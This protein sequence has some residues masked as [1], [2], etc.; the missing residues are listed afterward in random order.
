MKYLLSLL[1]AAGIFVSAHAAEPSSGNPAEADTKTLVWPD[2]TRY[3]GSVVDDK[4]SGKGTIIWQ[5]G[6]RFVGTFKDDLRNGPGTMI[7]PDGTVYNGYF[8]NDVLVDNQRAT[9]EASRSGNRPAEMAEPTAELSEQDLAAPSAGAVT[10]LNSSVQEDLEIT[11]NGWAKA[12]SAQDVDQ[13][14]ANYADEFAVPGKQTRRQWN[15]LRSSRLR[16]P[17]SITVTLADLDYEIT[18]PDTARIH[19]T[20]TYQSDRYSDVTNKFLQLQRQGKTWL[21]IKEGNR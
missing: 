8:E 3:V 16:A 9:A 12:W 17:K 19:F 18:K 5:D 15:A 21:I 20:Q 6:T 4:R 14:L 7:L 10:T 11:I 1:I 13:Y 2:G